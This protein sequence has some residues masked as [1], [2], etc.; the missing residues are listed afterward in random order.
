MSTPARA[1]PDTAPS[2][3]RRLL[4]LL[5]VPA[6]G[7][8]LLGAITGEAQRRFLESA[9]HQLCTPLAGISAQL[10]LMTGNEVNPPRRGQLAAVLGGAQRLAHTTQQ[11]L[12][13]ARSDQAANP[14]FELAPV[15]LPGLIEVVVEE[16]LAAADRARIDLG[17]QIEPAAVNGV[18]WL[19]HEALGNLVDNAIAHTPVG[20]SVTVQCGLKAGAPFLRVVDTGVGIPPDERELVMERFH[21]GS[22]ARGMGSG[23]GLPIVREVAQLHGG[24]VSIEAVTAAAITLCPLGAALAAGNAPALEESIPFVNFGS[25]YDWKADGDKGL[26]IEDIRHKWYYATLQGPCTGLDFATR[27]GIDARPADTF[28]GFSA[29]VVP[30]W[31]R[32]VVRSLTA[33]DPPPP[34]GAAAKDK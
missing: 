22:N 6:I 32:C 27:I 12:T 15:D 29:I 31:G 33:S 14:Q 9:A 17:A 34:K 18:G 2:I 1:N 28:D 24:T 8:Q 3:R 16:R 21:R 25:I 7:I 19:L 4:V 23:L 10:G 30:G 26:W 13:L 5:L 20:G 11:L